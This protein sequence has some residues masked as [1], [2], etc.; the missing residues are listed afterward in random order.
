MHGLLEDE[1]SA[2]LE[3]EPGKFILGHNKGFT[4]Y[5]GRQ[6]RK[7]PMNDVKGVN[8]PSFRVLD[9][10]M[11]SR[12][13]IWSVIGLGGLL[14]F[15]PGKQPVVYGPKDGLWGDAISL[16]C[17]NRDRVWVGTLN[18]LYYLTPSG[19][20][21]KSGWDFDGIY[22]RRLYGDPVTK[23]LMYIGTATHGLLW[24]KEGYWKTYRAEGNEK[25][26]GVYSILKDSR[27]RLLMGTLDG[28]YTV[29]NDNYIKFSE[30]NFILHRPVFFIV[31]DNK[32]RLWLGTDNGVVM[33]D[34][35]RS[36]AFSMPEG[37]I[38]N[39]TNRAA[40]IL[41]SIG[42]I[43]IGTNRGV[44]VYDGAFDNSPAFNPTPK[45]R[46]ISVETP[47]RRFPLELNPTQRIQVGYVENT[48]DFRFRGISFENER[49]IRF[50]S[51][52]EGLEI[53]WSDE[54]YPYNQV[55][56]YTNLSPGKYRFHIK[57]RNVMDTWSKEIVSP[58]ITVS[59]PFYRQWWFLLLV[60]MGIGGLL[61]SIFQYIMQLRQAANLKKMVEE[62][63]RDLQI[64]EQRY[65]RLFEDIRDVV[66]ISTP[67]GT[68]LDVN[69]VG[70]EMFGY[71][72]NDELLKDNRVFVLYENPSDREA[73]RREI[74]E[75]GFVKDFEVVMKR[76]NGEKLMGQITASVER[77]KDG[78]ISAYRGII[79]DVTEK[80]RLEEQLMQAQKME[81]IGTLAGGIAHDFNNILGVILGYTELVLEDLPAGTQL[82][83]N[84]ESIYTAAS[85]AAELVK[86]ILA[87]SRQG[88][89]TRQPIRLTPVIQESLKLLRSILPST[90]TIHRAFRTVSDFALAD[91]SQIHQIMMNLCSNA[92]HAM[93][94]K[95]GIL[96][97]SLD[98]ISIAPAADSKGTNLK[99]GH[100][101]K[102]S[103]KDTG[104]GM[105]E[106][107]LKRIFEPYFTTKKP[108]EGTGMGLAVIHGI[109]KIHGGEI[110]VHSEPGKGSIF[111]VYLP[112][113][114]EEAASEAIVYA[115][116]VGGNECILLVDDETSLI[117]VGTLMLER[118]GYKVVGKSDPLEALDVFRKE[119]A[120]YDL[121]ISDVTM[122]NMT[123]VRLSR[124]LREIKPGIPVILCSGFS[125]AINRDQLIEFGV[126][127]FVMKPIIKNDLARVV[128]RVID[129]SRKLS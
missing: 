48:L 116:I 95:G 59:G 15:N 79:R 82:R 115:E 56:R 110:T 73:F 57:A 78:N 19:T 128:R 112:K 41:D 123:G 25:A 27:G 93:Q 94:E 99:P 84:V 31:E 105:S 43:W 47:F 120:L 9:I 104:Y 89:R 24:Y 1:V 36:R 3:Y 85:R 14:K 18:G 6:F 55:I 49:L 91:G 20:V 96:E 40:G 113:M 68:L 30:K 4:Y 65:R 52:L 11:D 64:A 90:I 29:K 58:W 100:Y 121:V 60:I 32:K 72:S 63:T 39:E 69:P 12:K 119:P 74:E 126:N 5:D 92:A 51:W 111:N 87:F 117:Q 17:D 80:K 46:L 35:N 71:D 16:W 108:G 33:W 101:L 97:I 38:G 118:L 13:T 125:S 102:L 70:L 21:I 83:Q 2:V 88:N 62:R 26:N 81:A 67:E 124:E 10:K 50:K 7:L 23:Q 122:P 75:N 37:L 129:E 76:K 22:L 86:Q 54:G 127:E 8:S 77:D 42:R 28:V 109:V 114:D 106:P 98:E 61:Y 107:I 66:F 44:S 53:N 45:I 34:G 103:V